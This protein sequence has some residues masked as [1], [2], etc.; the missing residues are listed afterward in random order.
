MRRV[1]LTAI[2][3]LIGMLPP[4]V[5][6]QEAQQP[7]YAPPGP[8]RVV[9]ADKY[10]AR[11][12]DL[13]TGKIETITRGCIPE[14][15]IEKYG[16]AIACPFSTR[17]A[18]TPRIDPVE[19]TSYELLFTGLAED[20]IGRIEGVLSPEDFEKYRAA[21]TRECGGAPARHAS[22]RTEADMEC[23]TFALLRARFGFLRKINVIP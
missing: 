19:G 20:L 9:V 5:Q 8:D 1:G 7:W 11:Y 18:F 12:I 17:S 3:M 14:E 13:N 21:E 23:D 22:S 6:G 15:M 16:R 4:A 2:L 10:S